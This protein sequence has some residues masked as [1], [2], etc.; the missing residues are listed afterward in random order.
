MVSRVALPHEERRGRLEDVHGLLQLRVLAFQLPD[1][2]GRRRGR[3]L[4]L[5]GVD[6]GLPQP[7]RSVSG[8]IPGR[9]ATV[10]IAS[11]SEA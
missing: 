8:F 11:H 5:A 7:L 2:P 4:G 10:L 9:P 1:L 3:A 6:R